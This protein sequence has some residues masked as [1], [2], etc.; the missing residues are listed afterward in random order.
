MRRKRDAS[1]VPAVLLF[2]GMAA[3]GS[4]TPISKIVGASFSPLLAGFLRVLLGSVILLVAAR[5]RWS[6]IKLIDRAD[7]LRIFA[8]AV[9]GM[10]GFSVLMLY[11]MQSAPGAVGATIMGMTPAVTALAAIM[12]TG[13]KGSWRKFGSVGLALL[14]AVVL[15]LGG[16]LGEQ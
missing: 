15:Q 2:F 4:A 14:G 8:I 9:F 5:R 1:H 11:G 10:F 3:F 13:E 6:E 16:E 7:W 12:F